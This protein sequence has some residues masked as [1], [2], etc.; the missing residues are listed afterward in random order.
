MSA[1]CL[2]ILDGQTLTEQQ[3]PA[4]AGALDLGDYDQLELV[5]SVTTAGTADE[6]TAP[7]LVLQHSPSSGGEVLLEFPTP[8]SVDLTVTGNTW[9][10]VPYFTRWL[11]WSTSGAL[12]SAATV[13]V[14]VVGRR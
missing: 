6:G 11:F 7:A 14:D 9:I 5:I 10:H 8:V 2:R 13:S 4:S 1:T 12:I 3:A